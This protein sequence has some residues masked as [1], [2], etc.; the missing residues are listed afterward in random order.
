MDIQKV[1]NTNTQERKSIRVNIRLAPSQNKFILN[2]NLSITKVVN[3]ALKQLGYVPPKPNEI[4]EEDKVRDYGERVYRKNK[5][6]R[7]FIKRRKRQHK[8]KKRRY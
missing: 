7:K 3:E 1:Q 6:G 8:S 5:R 2:N 4:P